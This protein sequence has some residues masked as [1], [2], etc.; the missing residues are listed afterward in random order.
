MA[1][2]KKILATLLVTATLVGVMAV[3]TSAVTKNVPLKDVTYGGYNV[4]GTLSLTD[5]YV[6]ANFTLSRIPNSS[7][8]QINSTGITGTVYY[9]DSTGAT[10]QKNFSNTS[11]SLSCSASAPTD[12]ITTK[13][14][15]KY[16]VDGAT[17]KELT[18]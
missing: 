12:G 6:T 1:K 16:L 10:V 15:A 8:V 4:S 18:T 7:V 2:I 14:T 17:I 13:A 3:P 9:S 11:K 5:Y